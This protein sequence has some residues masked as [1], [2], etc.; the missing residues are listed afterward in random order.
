[1]KSVLL[2]T[3]AIFVAGAMAAGAFAQAGSAT[4]GTA[5]YWMSAETKSGMAAMSG[6]Q[7][8]RPNIGALLSGRGAAQ[9]PSFV[10]DLTL[11]LGSPRR[12]AGAPSAEHVPP[13]GLGAGPSLP[14]VT[15][16]A[17]AAPQAR[18]NPMGFGDGNARGRILIYWGCGERARAGQP[19]EIDLARLS[20]GQ[21]PPAMAALNIRPMTPPAPGTS[22]TYGDWPNQR[23]RTTIPA[24]GSLVGEHVV[25]GNYSPEIRFAL[26]QSQD[27]LPPIVLTSNTAVASGA[28]PVAW[29]PVANAR[30]Y[31][32][33]SFGSRQD[34]TMVMWSSSEVQANM[35]GFDYLSEGEIA[36]LLQQRVLLSPQTTQC[37]VPA[38]VTAGTQGGSLMMNAFGPEANFSHPARPARAPR[39]WAPE[40]TVKLRTRASYMGMLGMDMDAMMRGETGQQQQPERR[41]RR[42][43]LDRILGQ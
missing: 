8:G 32:L 37:T 15:P 31:F 30:A 28:V 29:Q 25:R 17:A 39:N 20:A 1:M 13:A 42:N 27:F 2:A 24:T 43:P 14:L 6:M 35:M 21:V 36:R 9:S 41:R 16:Q 23:S 34:G 11:Q 19:V 10:R 4:G 22:G 3:A 40:W 26:N 18:P 7:G 12:A 33:M 38:E 5:E